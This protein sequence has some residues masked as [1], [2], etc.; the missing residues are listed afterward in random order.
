MDA[1]LALLPILIV[2]FLM[3]ALRWSSPLAGLAG[4]LGSLVVAF[5]AFGLNWPV[6][7]VSQVKGLLLTMNVLIVLWPGI[8]LY[9]IVDQIGGI[10]AIAAAL[11]GMVRDRG[12]LLVLQAWMLAAIIESLAGFGLPIAMTAPLLI[13]L[14][15]EPITAVSAAA[16]GH[17][18]AG[19]T[20]GM[21]ISL[22]V[23]SGIT[24]DSFSALFPSAALL[25][26]LAMILS[27]LAAAWLLGQKQQW[28]RV[29]V[30][31]AVTALVHYILGAIGLIPI[32][33]LVASVVGFGVGIALSRN[34]RNP[35][36]APRR[37]PA[38]WAGLIAYGILVVVMLL[39]SLL[40]GLNRT[41]S[42]YTWTLQFPAVTTAASTVTPAEGGYLLHYFTHPGGLIL[43]TIVLALV[44]FRLYPQI[45]CPDLRAA[46]RSTVQSG[47]PASLGTLF[48]IGLSTIMEHTGMTQALATALSAGVGSLYPLFAPLIGVLGSFATGSNVNSNVLFG[49]LQREVAVLVGANPLTVLGAQT[50]GGSLGSSIAPAKL[51][52]GTSTSSAKGHEGEVLRRTLPISLVIAL[53]IGLV[54]LLIS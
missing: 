33:A 39:V 27:G 18:W 32:S 48:M 24:H 28:W 13:A 8:F 52:I 23:L 11:Q 47:I 36:P 45:P 12:W 21:A 41:L 54:T 2:I 7:W 17:T 26:G 46:W 51:A 6:F 9:V 19:S 38:L 1:L 14:G 34:P 3:V 37:D 16:V 35:Q 29:L 50:T 15:V 25:L 53:L 30:T 42:A 40:P 44:V 31:G 43:I 22:Q 4:W 10:R 49:V 5:L 20:G